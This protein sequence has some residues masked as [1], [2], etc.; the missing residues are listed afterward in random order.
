M[1]QCVVIGDRRPFLVALVTLDPEEAAKYAAGA[2]LPGDP[3]ALAGNAEVKA[4]IDARRTHRFQKFAG[5]SK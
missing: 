5:S 3:A 2:E 1:S 4:S